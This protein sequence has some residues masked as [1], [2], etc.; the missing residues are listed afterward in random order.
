MF[1][2]TLPIIAIICSL[3]LYAQ[4]AEE[5]LDS[6]KVTGNKEGRTYAETPESV[7]ILP[8]Q[9]INRG[10]QSNSL[11]VLNG[12]ANVQVGRN[13]ETFSIRGVNNTGVTGFQKDNLASIYVDD[14]FQTDLAMRAGAFE[15]WDMEA[16]ELYRGPQSTSQGV[17]SLA[18]AI[19]LNHMAP[20]Q[21][22]EAAVKLGYGSYNRREIGAIANKAFIND[23]LAVRLTFNKDANDGFITN[24]VTGNEKWGRQDKGHGVIDLKYFFD[25][26]SE[27]RFNNK[28][29]KTDMGGN[30]TINSNPFDYDVYE[31]KDYRNVTNNQQNSLTYIKPINERFSNKTTLA[32]SQS[33]QWSKADADGKATDSL[34]TRHENSNDQFIS[35]E[36]VLKFENSKIKNALGVHA[37]TFKAYNEYEFTTLVSNTKVNVYQDTDRTRETYAI[38]DSML[39]RLDTHHSLNLGARYEIVNYDFGTFIK[40]NPVVPGTN[41]SYDGDKQSQVVLPKLGWIYENAGHTY[42]LTFSQGYRIGGVDINRA[43]AKAVAYD[44][45][46]TNNYELSW[47]W[48]LSRVKTQVNAF[49]TKWK[50][51]Q[52]E[53]RKSPSNFYDSQVENASTSELYGAE[54]EGVY[55]FKNGDNIR[56]GVGYVETHFL[57]FSNMQSGGA[58]KSY[59]GNS[60]PDAAPWTAQTA[61]RHLFTDTISGNATFRYIGESY[62]NIDNT[63]KTGEQYYTDLNL[64][65]TGESFF[66]ELNAKNI[67]NQQYVINQTGTAGNFNYKRVNRPTELNTRVTWF[68]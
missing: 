61:Y 24:K 49:Y 67:F 39:Y 60:F 53:V 23:K 55:D 7:T 30:Y 22:T 57:S 64:T 28:F 11:E 34:G 59:T 51:Q 35:F 17:N 15:V 2:K 63:Y 46:K 50:D 12:Q 16:L 44:P 5:T 42:G 32:F 13:A 62:N 14:V 25:D 20:H 36:N 10:D 6:I 48:G 45:E 31:D 27:L 65:Y 9:R 21:E 18:G 33:D 40:T 52:V 41:G 3:P 4:D 58:I 1:K 37:H 47:K 38:F 56:L 68:F 26:K 8:P 19:I 29:L 43:N 54:A 66:W